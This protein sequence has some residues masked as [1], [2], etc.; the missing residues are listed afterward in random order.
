MTQNSFSSEYDE[1]YE[2]HGNTTIEL[3]RR[4][5]DSSLTVEKSIAD[6]VKLPYGAI[7]STSI[8]SGKLLSILMSTAAP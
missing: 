1:F 5:A 6:R 8:P 4:Q 3:T 2:Y 7:G